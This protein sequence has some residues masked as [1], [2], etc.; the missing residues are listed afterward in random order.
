[1][2]VCIHRQ[3]SVTG[4]SD[5][6]LVRSASAVEFVGRW[7]L[8]VAECGRPFAEGLFR[9]DDD[10]GALMK[11][12]DQMEQGLASSL[13]ERQKARRRWDQLKRTSGQ[14]VTAFET[15]LLDF[16]TQRIVRGQCFLGKGL[17]R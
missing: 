14:H 5:H 2:I 17:Y 8:G 3:A 1:M 15:R 7:H 16:R 9:S 13:C 11:P 4:R 6:V 12:S 10:R